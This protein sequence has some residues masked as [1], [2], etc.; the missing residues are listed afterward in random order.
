MPATDVSICS[1]ALLM[2][3]DHPIASLE[4][5]TDRARLA[6]NLWEPVRDFVLRSHPWN[7][8]IKRVSLAPDVA[9]PAFDW[10]YQYTLPEDYMKALS[11]GESGMEGEY[12]IEGRKLL[13][14][15]NP[16]LLRYIF[17][18]T[19]V[20]SYDTMLVWALTSCMRAVFAYPI[21]Q[22]GSLE[23]LLT[24]TLRPLLRQARAVDGQED[25]PEQLGDN[26]LVAAR[27]G[28][29]GMVGR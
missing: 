27:F 6:A 7:C 5:N 13:A 24:T 20:G 22:S 1:N 23:E 15:D 12:R 18:N 26:P 29:F 16:L 10:A 11:V 8:A 21:S 14:D 19:N 4:D 3:G 2:L 28:G 25:T 9:A 17:K